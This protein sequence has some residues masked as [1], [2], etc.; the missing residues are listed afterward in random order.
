MQYSYGNGTQDYYSM[1]G[2]THN[3]SYPGGYMQPSMYYQDAYGNPVVYPGYN[4]MNYSTHASAV[5]TPAD[6]TQATLDPRHPQGHTHAYYM[7]D[8]PPKAN[9]VNR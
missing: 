1:A 5:G 4:Q 2:G 8:Q 6:P 3:Y 9:D 7:A